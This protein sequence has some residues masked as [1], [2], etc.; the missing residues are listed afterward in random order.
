MKLKFYL[1]INRQG[2]VRT[3]KNP[4]SIEW[5]EVF[6]QCNLNIGDKLFE[7]PMLQ[8]NIE[9]SDSKMPVEIDADVV[10]DIESVVEERTGYEIK[11][12]IVKPEQE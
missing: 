8:A 12:Q 1:I 11:L 2:G 9:I 3:T 5:N 4:P 7:R 10:A 6:M